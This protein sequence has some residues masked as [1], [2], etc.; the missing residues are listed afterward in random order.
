MKGSKYCIILLCFK[1]NRV[2]TGTSLY[3]TSPLVPVSVC[4]L[5][6]TSEELREQQ[7]SPERQVTE[8]KLVFITADDQEIK[9]CQ[10][11]LALRL[12]EEVL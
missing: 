1:S 3:M 6:F 2:R 7:F 11:S 8:V 9:S 5:A 4:Q 12:Y 10:K